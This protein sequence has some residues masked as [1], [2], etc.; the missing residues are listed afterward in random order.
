MISKVLGH[1]S[2]QSAKAYVHL[3]VEPAKVAIEK[4]FGGLHASEASVT[5]NNR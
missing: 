1:V 2:P 5:N 4:V 3:D